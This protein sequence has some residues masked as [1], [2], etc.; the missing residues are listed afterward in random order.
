MKN[1]PCCGQEVKDETTDKSLVIHTELMTFSVGGFDLKLSPHEYRFLKSLYD[2]PGEA[3]SR[4]ILALEASGYEYDGSS[5]VVDSMVVGI[6]KKLEWSGYSIK[7]V[8]S[9]GYMLVKNEL[10]QSAA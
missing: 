9:V 4:E 1:C 5:R 6:R 3:V 2:R 8:R 7:G 10:N